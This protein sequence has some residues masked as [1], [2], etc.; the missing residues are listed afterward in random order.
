MPITLDENLDPALYPLAWLIGSW[1]GEGAVNLV[2]EA[3]QQDGRACEQEVIATPGEDGA[4]S[5]TMRTW[6]LDAPAP[7]PPTAA[8]AN[9]PEDDARRPDGAGQKDGA[10]GDGEQDGPGQDAPV[11]PA[12]RTLLVEET[13]TWR[14]GDPLPGQDLEAA[15]TAKPGSPESVVSYVL[16]VELTGDDG[17]RETLVGEVRGPRI[18]L[19]TTAI[20]DEGLIPRVQAERRM[21]GYVGGKLMWVVDRMIEDRD[22]ASWISAELERA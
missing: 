13:G 15:R 12:T 10:A 20:E 2:D 4:L 6:V 11:G 9:G 8:F 3:G 18:Q 1:H 22:M 19:A 21:L 7:L 14:V 16:E 17:R 5:W